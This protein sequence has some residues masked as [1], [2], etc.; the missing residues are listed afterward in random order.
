M[1]ENG[2]KYRK[3]NLPYFVAAV[4]PILYR[5]I[6]PA[7]ILDDAYITMR[8]AR[9]LALGNGAV[10]N[11]GQKVFSITNLL[12]M[13]LNALIRTTGLDSVAIIWLLCV[14]S[15]IILAI[16]IVKLGKSLLGSEWTGCLASVF[17]FTN[18]VFL[19]SSFG[20]ME[21]ALS[22]ASIALTFT[23]V[24]ERKPTLALFA[25]S[26]ALWIRF[27]NILLLGIVFLVLAF[28]KGINLRFKHLLPA[29]LF[30]GLYI[31]FTWAYYGLPVPVSVLRKVQFPENT[32]WF[33]GVVNVI[34]TFGLAIGG[35]FSA[36]GIGKPLFFIIPPLFITG[37]IL[38][39]F[40]KKTKMLPIAIYTVPYILAFTL[41]GKNYAK[42]FPWYFVPHLIVC[43]LL[44]AYSV[45]YFVR[46]VS[47]EKLKQIFTIAVI[48]IIWT[49]V[50]LPFDLAD[51]REYRDEISAIRER[52]YASATVW[53]EKNIQGKLKIAGG[54]IGAIGFFAKNET[55]VVDMVG[56][57]RPL[58]DKRLPV[59]LVNEKNVESIIYWKLPGQR[60]GDINSAYPNYVFGEVQDVMIGIR[61]DIS[62]EIMSKSDEIMEIYS[63]I[64]MNSD[65]DY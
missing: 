57:T 29:I 42:L 63:S 3:A 38:A 23:L 20:G 53:L 15:E 26:I 31:A 19:I 1:N 30:V 4:V 36:A 62:D 17:L 44:A 58:K 11:L 21:I 13:L 18:P 46:K 37:L 16:A 50:M 24:A 61:Y 28:Q 32:G 47:N 7:T 22:L 12:W 5:A 9:N 8:V 56:L 55:E 60:F 48:S 10:F 64:D 14:L 39:I 43:C 35:H 51:A 25:A 40:R 2:N 33:Y 6:I 45:G 54:E 59:Q 41:S 27:D 49:A 34:L 52:I 65:F